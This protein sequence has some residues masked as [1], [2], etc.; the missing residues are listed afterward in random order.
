MELF[1]KLYPIALIAL[2]WLALLASVVVALVFDYLDR[3]DKV[4]NKE[5][6]TIGYREKPIR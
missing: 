2:L 3:K 6:Q 4:N 5:Q 1:Y